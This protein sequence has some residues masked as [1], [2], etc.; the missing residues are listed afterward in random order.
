VRCSL[1]DASGTVHEDALALPGQSPTIVASS[2]GWVIA[3]VVGETTLRLQPLDPQL[4]PAGAPA[5]FKRSTHLGYSKAGALLTPTPS[6]FALVGAGSD[7]EHDQLLRLG[8]D[9][10]PLGAAIPLGR[11]FWFYG[12]VVASDDRAAVSLSA[13]Y[14]SYLLLLDAEKVTAELWI[15][16]G[17][18]TGMDEA[19]LLEDGTIGAAWLTRE[20][21]QAVRQRSFADGEDSDIGLAPPTDSLLGSP[22]EGTDSYQQLLRVAD[23]TLLVARASRYGYLATVAIRVGALKF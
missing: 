20:Q 10:K 5:D 19:L 1:V 22:E 6:G 18:K 9:L 4:G 16:G 13:P 7:D 12:Q 14:G 23:Q 15:A 17:G 11:D 3:Y 21:A 8:A 2:G